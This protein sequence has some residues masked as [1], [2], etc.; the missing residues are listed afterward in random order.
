M[1]N[2]I[3]THLHE[4]I[5]SLTK[6]EKRYFKVFSSRHVI[7]EENN[8][9]KLFD[10]I[11]AQEEY[12]ED[13]ILELFHDEAFI[14]R[15]SI[16]KNRLYNT[17]L[18]CLDS[19][20]SNNSAEAQIKRQIH[21]V[22]ILFKKGL[23]LQSKRVLRSA[24]RQALKHNKITS[25]M[26]I[27]RWEKKLV[28]HGQYQEM[29]KKE[30]KSI[31]QDDL[32]AT[33]RIDAFNKLWN[34]K[35]KIFSNLYLHGKARSIKELAKYKK[36]LDELA[37]KQENEEL[38]VEKAYLLNHLYSAYYFGVSDEKSSYPYLLQNL[39][40]IESNPEHF[41]ED[42]TLVLPTLS[43]AI[44][45][46]NKLGFE[47]EAFE[48]L[49]KL[50]R[51]PKTMGATSDPDLTIKVFALSNS[52]ELAL[53]TDHGDFKKAIA[54]V[55][56]IED[57]LIKYDRQLSSVHKASFYFNIGVL[58]FKAGH[59]NEALKWVNQLLNH[60]ET[61]KIQ[62]LYCMGQVLNLIIHMDL[63][64]RSLMPYAMRS[65][66]RF[67]ETRERVYKFESVMLKYVNS[68]LRAETTATELKLI[69]NLVAE[70]TVL[71]KDP[72]ERTIYEYFDFLEWAV[73]K[74][75]E[76]SKERGDR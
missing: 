76:L 21:S 73:R 71:K 38:L 23:Y 2:T 55:S 68:M 1:S 31:L 66:K 59:P 32:L 5:H 50:R 41:K 44:Y 42:R 74:E 53:L 4:L 29:G 57:G 36:I 3:S 14:H 51:L 11:S 48:N 7:G 8:Y 64:N 52:L 24:K 27:S 46:G 30:L 10:A 6:P 18:R 63:G 43:N 47:K 20:H 22:E 37:V 12:D 33:S 25:Q 28:E 58:F 49:K 54:L 75:N 67:L 19:Y 15:F 39:E 61:D 26:E 17:I 65:T 40:L 62:D 70:L 13:E 72:F 34:V 60:I 16:T 9:E 45:V 69:R 35:S 56:T